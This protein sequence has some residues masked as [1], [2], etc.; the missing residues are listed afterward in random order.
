MAFVDKDVRTT[1]KTTYAVATVGVYCLLMSCHAAELTRAGAKTII[2][3]NGVEPFTEFSISS[4]QGQKLFQI[5]NSGPLL[6]KVFVSE[7]SKPC[8]PDKSDMRLASRQFALC[9]QE[10]VTPDITWQNP[11]LLLSLKTPIK[12]VVI[13]ITGIADTEKPS[14]KMV[15][16]TWQFDFSSFPKEMADVLKLPVRAGKALFRRYDDGWRFVNVMTQETNASR[17]GR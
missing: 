4:Q 13:E 12:W 16:Y 3:K 8:L 9:S 15:E 7:K 6:D 1:M 5:P 17:H 11:G 10:S 2:E 14:E